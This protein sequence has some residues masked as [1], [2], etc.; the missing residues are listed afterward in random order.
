LNG[1][2]GEHVEVDARSRVLFAGRAKHNLN[3]ERKDPL[4]HWLQRGFEK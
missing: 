4:E 3:L 2:V 1:I